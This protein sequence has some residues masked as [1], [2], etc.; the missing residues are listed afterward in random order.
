M[1]GNMLIGERL[2][3]AMNAQIGSELGASNQY[4]MIATY[5]ERESLPE[6]AAFFYR[7]SDEEREHSMKFVHYVSEAGGEVEIPAIEKPP[8]DI[9]AADQAAQMALDWEME[10]T[11]Q[12]NALMDLA[13]E[14][15]DHIAQE[16]LRWF[17]TE[18][19]EEVSTMSELLAV[20]QRAGGNLL[21]V[22]D[23]ITRKGDPHTNADAE[24]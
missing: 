12:I 14:E 17:T 23:Y 1:G 20:I 11:K 8:G 24:G 2:V 6:L 22:E 9:Q 13:I 3:K 10:V 4:L 15:K 5:F 7:Q 18:Q 21:L 16:F 19:L